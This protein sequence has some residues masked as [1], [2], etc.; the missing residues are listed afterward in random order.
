VQFVGIEPRAEL[1][2]EVFFFGEV[3]VALV[4]AAVGDFGRVE[5]GTVLFGGTFE[6][7]EFGERCGA[8][9][10]FRFFGFFFFGFFGC[11]GGEWTVCYG[12]GGSGSG[13]EMG[14]GYGLEQD[15]GN[16]WR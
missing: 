10:R 15:I 9:C 3:A 4:S 5:F 12:G 8:C 6:V 1:G 11:F 13:G 2:F 16:G 7:L 14:F